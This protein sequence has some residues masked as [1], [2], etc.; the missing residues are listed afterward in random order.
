M[1]MGT[2]C[3]VVGILTGELARTCCTGAVGSGALGFDDTPVSAV[4]FVGGATSFVR[5][6]C[7]WGTSVEVTDSVS[8]AN[9][10]KPA[11]GEKIVLGFTLGL[12]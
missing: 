4:A 6:D 9:P 8:G 12:I 5:F 1:V 2:P 10:C 3:E 7:P 11:V